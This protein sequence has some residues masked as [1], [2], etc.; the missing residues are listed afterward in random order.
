MGD[1]TTEDKLKQELQDSE[2]Y[3]K[4]KEAAADQEKL[5]ESYKKGVTSDENLAPVYYRESDKNV[6]KLFINALATSYK[7]RPEEIKITRD[8]TWRRYMLQN[9][10]IFKDREY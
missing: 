2:L 6:D 8:G 10:E 1:I 3:A 9:K 5:N 4:E 7:C